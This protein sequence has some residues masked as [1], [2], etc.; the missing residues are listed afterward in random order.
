[1]IDV[2]LQ[3]DVFVSLGTIGSGKSFEIKKRLQLERPRQLLIFDPEGEYGAFGHV[4][5]DVRELVRA[6]NHPTFAVVW[7]PSDDDVQM[8]QEFGNICSA[9]WDLLQA[10]RPHTFVVDELQQVTD[11]T[12]APPVWRKLIRRGRKRGIKIRAAAQRPAEIDK[13]IYS[14]ATEIRAGRLGFP[15][16]QVVI[17]KAIGCSPKEIAAL[18]GYQCMR[19][20]VARGIFERPTLS[21][22]RSIDKGGTE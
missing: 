4:T 5:S 2:D 3:G 8:R 14:L 13:T 6:V 7:Y 9:S 12:R 10:G 19:W 22:D 20:D 17:A 21:I 1:M 15:D 18:Q 11:P 16:D